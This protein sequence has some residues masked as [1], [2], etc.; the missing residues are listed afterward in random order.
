[1]GRYSGKS[2]FATLH[3]K[4][5]LGSFKTRPKNPV[6]VV[7]GRMDI[8]F[9]GSVLVNALKGTVE[10]GPG[11]TKEYD[12]NGRQVYHGTGRLVVDGQWRGLQWFGSDMEAVWFGTGIA[13]LIGEFD[14]NL[15]T[16]EYWFDDPLSKGTWSTHMTTVILPEMRYGVTPGVV[17][18]KK[19]EGGN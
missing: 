12:D 4:C 13:S 9:S 10:V 6:G 3:L 11:L 8:T 14:K 15:Y 2:E 17:P 7:E 19:G 18:T 16:G 1:M 5:G